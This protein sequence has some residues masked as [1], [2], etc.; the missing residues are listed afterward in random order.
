MSTVQCIAF[1]QFHTG[2]GQTKLL[3]RLRIL[4]QK[5]DR[6]GVVLVTGDLYGPLDQYDLFGQ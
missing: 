6:P 4:P 2:L 5:T 3:I 1:S